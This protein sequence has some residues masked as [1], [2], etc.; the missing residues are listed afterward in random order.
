VKHIKHEGHGPFDFLSDFPYIRMHHS[1][2]G[3]SSRTSFDPH[4]FFNTFTNVQL[5]RRDTRV[6]TDGKNS[7]RSKKFKAGK[8]DEQ[9][10]YEET[11]QYLPTYSTYTRN[12]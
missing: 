1:Y 2:I 10:G 6:K 9:R 7:T 8:L 12:T 4:V 11:L 5:F 3:S